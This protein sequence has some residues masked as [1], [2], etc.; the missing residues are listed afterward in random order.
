MVVPSGGHNGSSTAVTQVTPAP[1]SCRLHAV[2]R[3]RSI[4]INDNTECCPCSA[5][6]WWVT[7]CVG[8][9]PR[10]Q[11]RCSGPG[12]GVQDKAAD[13]TGYPLTHSHILRHD[14]TP[15]VRDL[16][17]CPSR[18]RAPGDSRG[19]TDTHGQNLTD[20]A[21]GPFPAHRPLW[22]A[23]LQGGTP[24]RVVMRVPLSNRRA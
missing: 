8:I 23:P 11:R 4:A 17:S 22:A 12:A 21:P 13:A 6:R 18:A 19:T 10:R 16:V 3:Q 24:T 9:P 5:R 1:R 14:A 7:S 20:S 2:R 15:R